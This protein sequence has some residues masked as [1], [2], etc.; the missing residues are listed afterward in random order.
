MDVEQR[1]VTRTVKLDTFPTGVPQPFRDTCAHD[2]A[3]AQDER[4][5]WVTDDVNDLLRVVRLSDMREIAQI[6]TGISLTGCDETGRPGSLCE[7]LVLAWRD[8]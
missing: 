7:P 8:V 1:G 2:I 3:L 6:R 5:L 4:E